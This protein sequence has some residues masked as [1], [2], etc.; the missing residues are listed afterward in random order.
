LVSRKPIRSAGNFHPEWGYL[1]PAP[2]FMRTARIVAVAMAVGATA[3]V[4]VVVS[5]VERSP[6]DVGNTSIAAHA[7]VMGVQAAAS[8]ATPAMPVNTFPAAQ[9][10]VNAHVNAQP[11]VVNRMS[12]PPT[13]ASPASAG[14]NEASAISTSQVA[15][16]V[17]AVA[18]AP[19]VTD[20]S[21]EQAPNEAAAT[22]DEAHAPKNMAKKHRAARHEP[23]RQ[24]PANGDEGRTKLTQ[25]DR[26]FGPTLLRL[27]SVRTGSS[28]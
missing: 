18:K 27:F 2:S 13:S 10:Q 9:P 24:W 15:A 5:L 8:E 19:P 20:V 25:N 21:P 17:A 1:A 11:A 26:G 4:G 7:L 12:L 14:T 6:G 22:P 16:S 3:G 28:Y 23:L